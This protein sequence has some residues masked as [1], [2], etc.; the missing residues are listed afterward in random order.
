MRYLDRHQVRAESNSA[1]VQFQLQRKKHKSDEIQYKY[2]SADLR[3]NDNQN[4][5]LKIIHRGNSQTTA[6]TGAKKK[7]CC[8]LDR[9]L[10]KAPHDMVLT[11]F[12]VQ[13]TG[14]KIYY[15]Y[16]YGSIQ[17]NQN[18]LLKYNQVYD[19]LTNL[20]E[21]ADKPLEYLDLQLVRPPEIAGECLLVGFKLE[22]PGNDSKIC[23]KVFYIKVNELHF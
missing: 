4:N 9:H 14:D 5:T 6:S 2:V 17:T 16:S 8:Y 10:V 15:R 11:S 3:M 21:G 12:D 20:T 19:C 1:L 13:S 7:D 18:R 22:R 23:Y